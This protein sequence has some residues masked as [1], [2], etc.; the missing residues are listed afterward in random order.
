MFKM[1]K[2]RIRQ[3]EELTYFLTMA[4]TCHNNKKE[5][6]KQASSQATTSNKQQATSKQTT[7][8]PRPSDR[9]FLGLVEKDQGKRN[10]ID[11][12]IK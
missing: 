7:K 6:K 12:I 8:Q 5:R 11:A 1:A 10:L 9:V 3:T 2:G 4:A